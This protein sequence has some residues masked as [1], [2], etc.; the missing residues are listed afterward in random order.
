[1]SQGFR[2][3]ALCVLAFAATS[4]VAADAP[5]VHT[6][7]LVRHGAYV[8]DPKADPELGPGLTA[9]GIAQAR[10]VGA[11]LRGIPTHID[12]ITS[13]TMTRARQTAAVVQELFPDLAVAASPL[14]AE[15]TPHSLAPVSGAAANAQDA[16][17]KRLDEAFAKFAAPTS[18]NR[19]D[20]LVCHGNV[21]RYFVM[22]ALGVDSRAWPV[23][24]VA[25]S[26][27]T[28]IQIGPNGAYRIIAVGDSGHVPPNML[29]WGGDDD[30][31]L[32]VPTR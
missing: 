27:I 5:A 15:C 7:Y 6:L 4:A 19:S 13:S 24:S 9:L 31:Q 8:A 23:M 3:V 20:V 30:P 22:K 14:L 11:R 16:C 1:M 25:H 28:I 21:I 12:A 10:L 26:S 17:Q 32:V 2:F 18:G 29:S